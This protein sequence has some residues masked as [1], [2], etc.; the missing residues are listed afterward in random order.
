ML[1]KCCAVMLSFGILLAC[2]SVEFG[3][4]VSAEVTEDF[5][6][7]V[8]ADV[9][10]AI[11]RTCTCNSASSLFS[12]GFV[13]DPIDLTAFG[14][15]K[16]GFIEKGRLGIQLDL[17]VSGDQELVQR[18]VDQKVGGQ[19]EITSAGKCDY[20]EYGAGA[21]IIPWKANGWTRFVIDLNLLQTVTRG[22]LVPSNWNFMRIY[23]RGGM[24]GLDGQICTV[25]ITK[26]R[27]V[28]LTKQAPSRMDDPIGDGT[29][30]LP[31]PEFRKMTLSPEFD[32]G[33]VV[34]AGYNLVESLKDVEMTDIKDY[35]LAIQS[36]LNALS[37]YGGGTLFL[38]A[39]IYPC[40]KPIVIPSGVELRGEWRDPDS[41]PAVKGTVL[42]IKAAPGSVEDTA[43]VTMSASSAVSDLAFWYPEQQAESPNSYAVTLKLASYARVNDITFVNS[44]IAMQQIPEP[45]EGPTVTNVYG[46][47]LNCGI[48]ADG[49]SGIMRLENVHFS[50]DYWI[51]S[52]LEN[53]PASKEQAELLKNELYNN[54]TGIL[55]RRFKRSFLT[56]YF[57]KG[58]ANG[59]MFACSD[60]GGTAAYPD[61]QCWDLT[62][63]DCRTALYAFGVSHDGM[64]VSD[65]FFRG[66]E[67]AVWLDDLSG[68]T[69]GVL[70]LIRADITADSAA[71]RC[72][73]ATCVSLLSSVI[74]QGRVEMSN[75]WL[76]AVDNVFYTAA[77]HITLESGTLSAVLSGNRTSSGQDIK[78][79]NAGGCPTDTENVTVPQFPTVGKEAVASQARMASS[80][81]TYI[82]SDLANTGSADV[83]N[84]LQAYLNTAA[85]TGGVVFLVPGVYRIDGSISVP[86]GVEL[87]G[88]C[89]FTQAP[90]NAGTILAVYQSSGNPTVTLQESS[91]IR[92]IT[93]DYPN[94]YADRRFSAYPAAIQ[95]H[96]SD[97][98]IINTAIRNGWDGVDLTS[99]TCDRHYVV[100]LCGLCLHEGITVG[101]GSKDGVL[102]NCRFDP[103]AFLR[104]TEKAFGLWKTPGVSVADLTAPLYT[105]LQNTAVA[106][107][108]GNVQN[109][110][111]FACGSY[112]G[113]TGVLLAADQS[114][115]ADV[116][117]LCFE[118]D[119]CTVGLDVQ[120]A[121]SCKAMNVQIG[122]GNNIGAYLEEDTYDI[123]LGTAFDGCVDIIGLTD[124]ARPSTAYLVENGT[125]NIYGGNCAASTDCVAEV[126][127]ELRAAAV[128]LPHMDERM[129]RAE[130]AGT[131]SLSAGFYAGIPADDETAGHIAGLPERID[132]WTPIPQPD[133]L[134]GDVNGA[135]SVDSTDARLILQYY[136]RKIGEDALD[137]S[138]ANVDGSGNADST[139]ARM[140]LQA[141]AKKIS[142]FETA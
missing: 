125:L 29:F 44:Y 123:R 28:D 141:Y 127:G 110:W 121:A 66:C 5:G 18:L 87:R 128:Y 42:A 19:I 27:L 89:D 142:G 30:E 2:V 17:Y 104:G 57:V 10:Y 34:I 51:D 69:D 79:K 53:A 72:S 77:P 67:N 94:Q 118:A 84:A 133:T 74:R 113:H 62:F 120:N 82:V 39:G 35:S 129:I 8:L 11:D 20:E 108:F 47:P 86:S 76:T 14:Y 114:G 90:Y 88:A 138:A 9:P 7:Y 22:E 119:N 131:V 122:S 65:A 61:G 52:G 36:A 59:L 134:P 81:V 50:P 63:E 3:G 117:L 101:G 98:Y 93:F 130:D 21:N 1:K 23:L 139:D 105:Q 41:S 103:T 25:K 37:T 71:L 73:G 4:N 58:Y 45:N 33:D 85:A 100:G 64:T 60:M 49:V 116:C 31:R 115:A 136:A 70:Q 99:F 24:D 55:L 68:R 80:K 102:R 56:S 124:F 32:N 78:V 95:G 15:P 13:F 75:G 107:R 109:E 40:E 96:G 38:P 26:A 54:G 16:S 106:Y 6:G 92:G 137:L 48:D 97:I 46:T 126:G 140:I 111:V 135:E 112:S 12:N 43:F 83:T 132:E 91:G